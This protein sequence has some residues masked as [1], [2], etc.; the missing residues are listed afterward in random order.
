VLRS[1]SIRTAAI[2]IAA[3]VV[4]GMPKAAFGVAWPSVADD[5]HREIA[6]LGLI[7]SIFVGGYFTG[8]LSAGRLINRLGTGAIL[9]AAA[10][11]ATVAIGGYAVSGTWPF[12]LLSAIVLG[13][14][15]GLLDAGLN[16]HVALHRGAR[17]MGWLHAGYGVGSAVGPLM[18]TGFLAI[19]AGWRVGFWIIAFLQGAVVVALGFTLRDW[20]GPEG[21]P[22]PT[23]VRHHPVVFLTLLVFLLYVGLE[24][25][26]AHWG[27]TLLTEGHS[28]SESAAGLAVTGFWIS[29]TGTRVLLGIAGDRTPH[30]LVA[31]SG[32]VAALACTTLLWW[33][34]S[35]WVGPAALIALGGVIG[36]IFPL[37]T[38]LTPLRVGTSAT[39]TMV[40]YQM[41]AASLGAILIPGGLGPLVG[42]FGV[43]IIAPVLTVAAGGLVVAGEAARRWGDR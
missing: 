12:L 4:L 21:R 35:S 29:L 19:D 15:G 25:A 7:V 14:A 38:L 43:E 9:T 30:A 32:A 5:L 11:G 40:G 28:L 8:T 10:G 16:A 34:P 26:A 17:V 37:Q 33:S 31:G 3:F 1:R 39:P 13:V 42:R 6:D 18:M 36:P 2:A 41:A 23:R 22:P 20:D 24:V 27:F